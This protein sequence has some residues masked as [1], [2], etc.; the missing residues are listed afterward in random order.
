MA[1]RELLRRNLL[2]KL[3]SLLLAVLIW[4]FVHSIIQ[5]RPRQF[6]QTNLPEVNR[7]YALPITIMT[8]ATEARGFHVIPSEV[9]VTVRGP[10]DLLEDL[11]TNQ[12]QVFV[13]LVALPDAP[14]LH[15]EIIVH[16]PADISLVKIRPPEVRVERAPP[17][18]S[19]AAPQPDP[20]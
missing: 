5:E 14:N 2:W 17:A 18:N 9:E 4:V 11:Q 6:L 10:A 3:V 1:L 12:I 8:T 7:T 20:P 19:S 13:D 16:T 15:R